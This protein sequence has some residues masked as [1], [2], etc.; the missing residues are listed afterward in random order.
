MSSCFAELTWK[1]AERR[2]VKIE[3]PN[4]EMAHAFMIELI[5]CKPVYGQC[6]IVGGLRVEVRGRKPK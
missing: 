3:M 1:V 6:K 4:E 5:Q 2:I